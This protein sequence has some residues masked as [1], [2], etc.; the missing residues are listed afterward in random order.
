MTKLVCTASA[1]MGVAV[2]FTGCCLPVPVGSSAAKPAV[3]TEAEQA[4][5]K[6]DFYAKL[7]EPAKLNPA[8]ASNSGAKSTSTKSTEPAKKATSPAKSTSATPAKKVTPAQS[9]LRRSALRKLRQNPAT[10]TDAEYATL[11]PEEVNIAGNAMPDDWHDESSTNP[12]GGMVKGYSPPDGMWGGDE[13]MSPLKQFK[14]DSP[15]SGPG[16]SAEYKHPRIEVTLF[17][18]SRFPEKTGS[19]ESQ[20][21]EGKTNFLA[22]LKAIGLDPSTVQIVYTESGF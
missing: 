12:P 22:Y 11:T 2:L 1:L 10:I 17:F 20:L 5:A 21:A 8:L 7:A 13:P 14:L 3:R 9:D 4:K 15:K 6:A 16:Y 18:E 19:V